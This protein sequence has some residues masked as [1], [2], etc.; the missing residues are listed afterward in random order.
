MLHRGGVSAASRQRGLHRRSQPD[1]AILFGQFQKIDH[2]SG[3]VLFAMPH[4]ERLPHHIETLRPEP[5]RW[6]E[7]F[8]GE[9]AAFPAGAHDDQVDAW[10]QGAKRLLTVTTPK[11]TPQYVPQREYGE[12]SWMV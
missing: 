2:L 9:C 5:A 7:G 4:Y 12:R 1:V 11:R 3:S 8:I 6:V 10:S